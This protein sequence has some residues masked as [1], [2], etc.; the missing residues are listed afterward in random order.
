MFYDLILA[1]SFV[2]PFVLGLSALKST[3]LI[4]PAR[5]VR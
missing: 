1:A 4:H 5:E 2:V 3:G